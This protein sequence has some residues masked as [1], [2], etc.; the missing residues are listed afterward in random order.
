MIREAKEEAG[1][2]IEKKDL[3][4]VHVMQR[5]KDDEERIDFFIQGNKW[6]GIPKLMEPDKCDD[7]SWFRFINY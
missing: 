1:L 4:I 7:L 5:K 6:K 2:I 3:E